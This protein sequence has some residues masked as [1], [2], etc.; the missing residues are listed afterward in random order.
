[1][2]HKDKWLTFAPAGLLTIGL[3]TCLVQW[4]VDKRRRRESTAEWV[5]AGTVALVVLNAGISLFGRGVT[6]KVLYEVHQ[7]PAELDYA[8]IGRL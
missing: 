4:A 2:T 8:N 1:M 6:E 5:S 3:G 7:K